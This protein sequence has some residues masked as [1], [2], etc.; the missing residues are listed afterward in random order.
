MPDW[1]ESERTHLQM[2]EDTTEGTPISPV[3]KTAEELARWL[4]DNNASSFGDHTATYDQWLTMIKRG[5]AVSACIS[6]S[7]GLVSGVEA[8][9][10]DNQEDQS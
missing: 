5:F 8:I 4:A 10:K 1:P 2:Y 9:S 7:R 3:M 6:P